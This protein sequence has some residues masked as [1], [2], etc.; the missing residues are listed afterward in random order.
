MWPNLQE[1]ADLVTFT[2]EILNGKVD[3]LCIGIS[4][5]VWEKK[6]SDKRKKGLKKARRGRKGGQG[7]HRG[8]GKVTKALKAG[9]QNKFLS[10]IL[11]KIIWQGK[12]ETQWNCSGLNKLFELISYAT[13]S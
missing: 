4:K 6:K 13:K 9:Y 7:M 12:T 10:C 3:F 11:R 8:W 5:K 1:T 2:E